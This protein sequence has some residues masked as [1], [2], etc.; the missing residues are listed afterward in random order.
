M[1]LKTETFI[2]KLINI[3]FVKTDPA[4]KTLSLGEKNSVL[5]IFFIKKYVFYKKYGDKKC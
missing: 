3:T 5:D 4:I 2:N 1:N